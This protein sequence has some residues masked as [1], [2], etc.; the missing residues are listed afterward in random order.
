MLTNKKTSIRLLALV[1]ALM[2]AIAVFAGCSK[3]DDEARKKAEDAEK[4][5]DEAKKTADSL[6][7]VAQDL[8]DK[9]A[10]AEKAAKDAKAAAD[11]AKAAAD[12][13]QSGVDHWHDGTTTAPSGTKPIGE[14][15]FTSITE[16]VKANYLKQFTELK[17]KFLITRAD[18]YT[19]S[20]YDVLAKVFEDASYE[21]YRLTTVDGV[22]QL[23]AETETK[24]NAV[25]NIV[26]D[27]AK[28][29]AM[30]AAFGDVPATLFTT[31]KDKVEAARAAFDKWVNDYSIRFFTKNGFVFVTDAKNNIKIPATGERKIVDFARKLT[32]NQVY[33]NVNENTNSLLYAEAKIAALL[34]YASDA[35]R[36]EMVA[37]LMISGGKTRAAAEAVVDVL[38]DENATNV[39]MNNAL[40][41]Y[42]IVKK[43]VEK[44]APTYKECKNNAQLIEDCYEVYRI[45]YNAN[46]GDDTPISYK[47]SKGNVL[48]TGEQFV[49]LYVLC[50]YDGELTE[51]ENM[52]FD[53]I[54]T[55]IVP[56]FLNKGNAS[57]IKTLTGWNT[58]ALASGSPTFG[59]DAN[60]YMNVLSIADS[61]RFTFAVEEDRIDVYDNNVLSSSIKVDGIK[62]QRD[63]N[64]VVAA[65]N[66]KVLALDYSTDFK[67]KKSLNDA[68]IEIDQIITKAIVDLAQVY[69]NDVI[70]LFLEV[71]ADSVLDSIKNVYANTNGTAP[72][73]YSYTNKANVNADAAYYKADNDFYLQAEALLTAAKKA[74]TSV[75]FKSYDD[76]NKIENK[77]NRV[78]N[79]SEQKLFDVTNDAN[80]CIASIALHIYDSTN[81]DDKGSSFETILKYA[82]ASMNSGMLDFYKTLLKV[83]LADDVHQTAIEYAK[84]LD[85]LV[86]IAKDNDASKG[87]DVPSALIT[88][89]GASYKAVVGNDNYKVN[90]VY[91]NLVA[92]RNTAR[93]DILSVKLLNDDGSF[94]IDKETYA[95]MNSDGKAWY[96]ENKNLSTFGMTT[97]A[98][99]NVAVQVVVDPEVV[100]EYVIISKFAAGADAVV[101]KF[102]DATRAII[103]S[104]L[105]ADLTFYG[106]KYF[107]DLD[108]VKLEAD[109]KAYIEFLNSLTD[110]AGIGAGFKTASFSLKNQAL[111]STA[112]GTTVV[113][114]KNG[115]NYSYVAHVDTM[116]KNADEITGLTSTDATAWYT[117][118][119]GNLTTYFSIKNGTVVSDG[120][121]LVKQ[122]SYKKDM[123]KQ[124]DDTVTVQLVNNYS[125]IDTIYKTFTGTVKDG[126]FTVNPVPAYALGTQH[127]ALYLSELAK[128]KE[129]V[130][131]KVTAVDLINSGVKAG[132]TPAEAYTAA[133]A[134][135]DKIM[136]QTTNT[137]SDGQKAAKSVDDYSFYIAWARYYTDDP[138]LAYDWTKYKG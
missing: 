113:M 57:E 133:L 75:E 36:E 37:Q 10:A 66:A 13:A 88:D 128:V 18:W 100:A 73:G 116:D 49:K 106:E 44:T 54:N 124:G 26:S 46:G 79:I 63:L 6:A 115:N 30:I 19:L 67:G 42:N 8:A 16:T 91:Q 107:G 47:D 3:A 101:L 39:Q 90:T 81:A 4:A 11:S 103:K 83:E 28:V 132:K 94:A 86:G 45:F 17:N 110:F 92:A 118:T 33:I 22:E 34:S 68:Y 14:G 87:F 95:A 96:T 129:R 1:L 98:K 125:P 62:I 15:E 7:K 5:A 29:Q 97:T 60:D 108:H 117:L 51:Y 59:Y 71:G 32:D 136:A 76:L 138:A 23:L 85:N 109:M 53:Y 104:S 114:K 80:G 50:L 55:K 25:P 12:A 70:S 121:K 134:A 137:V 74:L 112:S 127:T 69:Y 89:F 122:L 78:Y 20:N 105:N 2:M 9:L 38:F 56:F 43:L 82:F 84:R 102:C 58:L 61:T 24:A 131:N 119:K 120:L 31:N 27:A 65:A 130:I 111:D 135:L 52:V 126:K 41:Q 35:I 72:T 21:L 123:L 93:T 99:N 64:R 48:L 40:D 77:K